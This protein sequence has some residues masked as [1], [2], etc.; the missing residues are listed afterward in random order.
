MEKPQLVA[1]PSAV[2][3]VTGHCP[4]WN[5]GDLV[6]GTYQLQYVVRVPALGGL[7]LCT[8]ECHPGG[9]ENSS[10][11]SL[12]PMTRVPNLQDLRTDDLRY[13]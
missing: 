12:V 7:I 13:S 6:Y 1:T 11:H 9:Q 4:C 8:W 10:G 3:L 5:P 2:N